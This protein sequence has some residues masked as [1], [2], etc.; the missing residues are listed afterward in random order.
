MV[1]S[2]DDFMLIKSILNKFRMDK[3][4]GVL[5]SLVINS[6]NID[7][8]K[9]T[10]LHRVAI[11][12]CAIK[13]NMAGL[14]KEHDIDKIIYYLYLPLK[15]AGMLHTRTQPHHDDNEIDLVVL[16]E[17]A[18]DWESAPLTKPDKQLS[19]YDTLLKYHPCIVTKMRPI[20]MELSLWSISN[21]SILT[22]NMYNRMASKI[23]NEDILSEVYKSEIYL[24][25]IIK[26]YRV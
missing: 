10:M 14:Y 25:S 3:Y 23:K 4:T 1:L 22:R 20:L 13:H 7:Y 15:E 5:G 12:Q 26:E 19:A 9:Y 24:S 17:K 6:P 16:Y 11:E 21:K 18:L 8:I 2:R